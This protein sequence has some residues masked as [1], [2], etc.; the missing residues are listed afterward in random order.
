MAL[1]DRAI[2]EL[3]PAVSKQVVRRIASHYIGGP[4]L[5]DATRVAGE[6]NAGRKLATVD[7]L[8]EEV[9]EAAAASR[10][11]GRLLGR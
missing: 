8:G 9:L 2:V 3:L 11:V 5:D 10:F 7:V 1:L 6:L 4:E